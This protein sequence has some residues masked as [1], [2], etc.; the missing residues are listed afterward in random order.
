MFRDL[1]E[2]NLLCQDLDKSISGRRNCKCKGPEA[3]A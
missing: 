3:E 2:K 1:S